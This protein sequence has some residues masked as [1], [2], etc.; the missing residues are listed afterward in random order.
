MP[1]PKVT[2]IADVSGKWN[3]RSS[4]AGPEYEAGIANPRTPW[5][6]AAQAAKASYDAGVQ[7]AVARGAYAKGVAAA[8]DSRWA[9]KSKEK[10]PARFAQGVAVSQADYERGFS[11]YLDAI[12]RTDLP[13]RGP[14][15]SEQNYARMAPIGKAL[16]ALKRK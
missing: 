9:Q 5:A 10:G 16:A 1:P 2:A 8:G 6:A 13:P 14:R 15:G 11:P 12:A 4:T 7:A 3:R